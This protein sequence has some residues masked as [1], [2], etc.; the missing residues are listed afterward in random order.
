MLWP[1]SSTDNAQSSEFDHAFR[2]GPSAHA[3]RFEL[4]LAKVTLENQGWP[5]D[6]F[7]RR[8]VGERIALIP[9]RELCCPERSA[10][11]D[12]LLA[13]EEP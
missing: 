9:V 5:P 4:R 8:E 13:H 2:T 7:A 12:T 6:R 3:E 11:R 10:S 1:R